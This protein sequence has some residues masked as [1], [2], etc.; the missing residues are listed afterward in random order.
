MNSRL[1]IA[2]FVLLGSGWLVW[3]ET[4]GVKMQS[5]P[6]Q[7]F[8]MKMFE[9]LNRISP[10]HNE[11]T[12]SFEKK[13]ND[14]LT[15]LRKLDLQYHNSQRK[16]GAKGKNVNEQKLK[17]DGTKILTEALEETELYL[18]KLRMALKENRKE[19]IDQFMP[20]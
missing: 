4:G 2:L 13:M 12:R 9:T 7:S 3:S 18:E 11:Q 10:S 20:E 1:L 5:N 14:F 6:S 16:G 19:V 15:E 8:M 17:E